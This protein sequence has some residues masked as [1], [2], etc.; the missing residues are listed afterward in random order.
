MI[1]SQNLVVTDG[2][3]EKEALQALEIS[4]YGESEYR[5]VM[6]IIGEQYIVIESLTSFIVW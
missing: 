5:Q 2:R 4:S 6:C 3:V 1:S